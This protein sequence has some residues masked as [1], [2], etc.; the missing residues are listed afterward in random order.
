MSALP[1][2]V[3]W[4]LLLAVPGTAGWFGGKWAHE[5]LLPAPRTTA[6]VVPQAAAAREPKV[7][8]SSPEGKWMDRARAAGPGDFAAL[9]DEL[10]TTFPKGVNFEALDAA[11]KW[12]LGLWIARDADAAAEYVA[13]KKDE[14]LG[15]SF[16]LV[17]GSVAPGKVEAIL[18][19][20][21][22][23]SFGK[24]FASAVMRSLSAT[25]PREYLRQSEKPDA[26]SPP[27]YW[28]RALGALA[29][30]DPQ[31]AVAE[32]SR[33][34]T[35]SGGKGALTSLLGVWVQRDAAAARR[36]VES[37]E[38]SETRKLA[39]HTWL[40]ALARQDLAAARRSLADL[41]AG[42]DLLG[43]SAALRTEI[44][45]ITARQDLPA[46][47]ADLSA[48]NAL[49]QQSKET[50]D[51]LKGQPESLDP[52]LAISRA[53]VKAAAAS[54]PD[55]PAALFAALKNL[56][57]GAGAVLDGSMEGD[58]ILGKMLN[59]DAAT[60]LEAARLGA[61]RLQAEGETQ[62]WAHEWLPR[63]V[64]N[65]ALND[66]AATV[67][68][69]ST[70]PSEVRGLFASTALGSFSETDP[71]LITR[72]AGF[73]TANECNGALGQQLAI[74]PEATAS[75]V[76]ALPV[77]INT[78]EARSAFTGNWAR[79]D[80]D[81]AAQWVVSLP[82]DAGTAQAARGVTDAW[83]RYD[84][85]AAS[86]WAASL[87]QGPAR[88][89]AAVGLATSTAAAEPESAWQWAA[90]ISDAS[91][92]ATAFGNVARLWGNE[93]PPEFR[94]ALSA[95]MDRSGYDAES[96]ESYLRALNQPRQLTQ[97]PP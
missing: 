83:A 17:L 54:L 72:A 29:A 18:N 27:R 70:L 42:E 93:A 95:A 19:G 37:L 43:A 73:L 25:D 92:S 96:R 26:K 46:A 80:P 20:P 68:F 33:W 9:L 65:A 97:P 59:K 60:V 53:I 89:G 51:Y 58:L 16:G 41:V 1:R 13:A 88:D 36:W 91:L 67:E 94:A 34:G 62:L 85:T 35:K 32:W 44:A 2:P 24:Y 55:E 48:M 45:A 11:Q 75:I 64:S 57:A 38:D 49:I 15:C 40:S 63:L 66:P 12:L 86:A 22:G 8:P 84:D 6:R 23:K 82:P 14:L 28:A 21:L 77:N 56:R 81:A 31:A 71:A 74:A 4:L 50:D 78:G 5:G 76:A 69:L 3:S 39:Q 47:L 30:T 10:D 61:E 87:P 90:S 7:E 79:R 52:R